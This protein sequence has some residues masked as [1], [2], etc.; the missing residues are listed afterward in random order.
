MT[1]PTTVSDRRP[2]S[3]LRAAARLRR[4]I[5]PDR[6]ARRVAVDIGALDSARWHRVFLQHR[7]GVLVHGPTG[8]GKTWRFAYH[9]VTDAPG[10][11]LATTTKSRD[12]LAA[13]LTTR[14]E[15]GE[16]GVFD[17]E[18]ITGWPD[19]L[20]WSI[21]AGCD[22][23]D[24]AIRRAAALAAAM[25]IEGTKNTGYFEGKAATL[26]RCYLHAAALDARSVR[27]VRIWINSRTSTEA[28]DILKGVRPDWA[29][30]LDEILGNTSDSTGDVVSACARLL[31]P[32]ASPKLL[33]A[34]DVPLPASLDVA[35]MVRG[36]A[37]TL[38]LVSE[39]TSRSMAPFVAALAHEAEH[40]LREDSQTR[41][42]GR[43]DPPARFV[44]D[45]MNNVAPLPEL[46]SKMTDTGGRGINLW[47]FAHNQEQNEMRW[48][49]AGGRML[50]TSAPAAIILPGLHGEDEL[51]S[52]SRLIGD[53]EHW[54]VSHGRAGASYQAQQ[55][56]I[57]TG[58]A[59]RRMG[60]DEALLLYRNAAPIKLH[61]PTVWTQRRPRRTVTA[62]LDEF[63]AIVSR[64]SRVPARYRT[65]SGELATEATGS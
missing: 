54:Q 44:L 7:D 46:P 50:F 62:A 3:S 57:M 52:L 19:R 10:F 6:F 24:T 34:V 63:D 32:L 9:L 1:R 15:H 13:T 49:R 14:A 29:A 48:G 43:L 47:C 64:R 18:N 26:L 45:E 2:S 25:P 22:Q 39:G 8:S 31:E 5:A 51:A 36:G 37:N 41:P 35:A 11:C 38:Y 61:V 33:A 58:A 16:I 12:V 17:P 30:E 55:R 60:D 56:P 59:I 23:P 20:R 4:A 42:G 40:H 65:R 53:R 21:L 28:R 27:D